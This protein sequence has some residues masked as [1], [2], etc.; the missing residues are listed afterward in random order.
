[1]SRATTKVNVNIRLE[2]SLKQ[3]I[4][5][6]AHDMWLNFTSVVNMLLVKLSRERTITISAPNSVLESFSEQEIQLFDDE[7]GE[8][9]TR[10]TDLI[11]KKNTE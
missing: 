2:K 4:E 8:T 11:A 6:I 5:D 9:V 1:M 3:Q 7:Y 10:V